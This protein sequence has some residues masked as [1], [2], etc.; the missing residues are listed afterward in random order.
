MKDDPISFWLSDGVAWMK[1]T[2]DGCQLNAPRVMAFVKE[3]MRRNCPDFAVDLGECTG[4]DEHFV[5]TL[6][7]IA[8]RL[9]ELG[10][11][12]LRVVRCPLELDAQFRSLAL[13]RLLDIGGS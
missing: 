4:M 12:K 2:G 8:L 6:A 11:G 7:G 1:P 9:Q 13:E 3:A 5:G 10:R